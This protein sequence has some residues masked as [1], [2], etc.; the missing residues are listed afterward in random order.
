MPNSLAN[1]IVIVAPVHINGVTLVREL[2]RKGA[3]V[4]A[5]A[6]D[7]AA[8]GLQSRFIHERVILPPP[9]IDAGAFTAFLLA[10]HDLDGAIVVPTED[11]YVR[12]L[13]DNYR[14]LAKRFRLA[15]SPNPATAIALDKAL[16]YRAC[17]EV[18]I[19]CPR[20]RPLE[21]DEDLKSAARD[22][23]FPAILRPAFS[24]A[25]FREFATKS[26]QVSSLDEALP[27]FHKAHSA[28]HALLFQ[29]VIPGPDENVVSCKS[30]TTGDGRVLGVLAG[31]KLAI[32][33]PGFGVSQVQETRPA[34]N[35]EDGTR[36]ILSHIGFAG[37]LSSVEWKLDPR[38]SVWKLLE[39]NARSVMAIALMKFARADIIDML[40]RDKTGLPQLPP[41]PPLYGRRWAYIKN[42][43]LLSRRPAS[44]RLPLLKYL[45]LYRPPI[46]FALFDFADPRPFL[47]DLAPLISRR[48]GGGHS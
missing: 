20:T 34:A 36:R 11:F 48:F 38:D 10:R 30:Y 45:G 29:E 8:A 7:P 21:T 12:E 18:G 6:S 4:V 16:T 42:G 26:F 25:F 44:E 5:V 19:P 32:Y 15:V 22:I 40:W 17:G 43:L 35:V 23:G 13:A 37:S 9:E 27:L 3:H 2:A 31:F 39:V 47:C 24:V 1:T 41:Q 28:G 14:L 46:C 33:P